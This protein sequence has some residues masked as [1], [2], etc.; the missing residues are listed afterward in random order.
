MICISC[1]AVI[2]PEYKF[3]IQQGVCPGCGQAMYSEE[4]KTLITEL[5]EVLQ[6]MPNDPEGLAGWFASNYEM[7]KIGSAEPTEFYSVKPKKLKKA[8]QEENDEEELDIEQKIANEKAKLFAKNAGVPNIKNLE[9]LAK[10][11]KS[12][13][14]AQTSLT[15][16]DVPEE[17]YGSSDQ[18]FE[19]EDP[20]MASLE[21]M[22]VNLKASPTANAKDMQALEIQKLKRLQS[23]QNFKS[24]GGSFTRS[25]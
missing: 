2:N 14:M 22:M 1:A 18:D 15:I 17:D 19:N 12:G 3:A 9:S 6:K 20:E 24:G 25:S 23:K 11:I 21:N 5:K 13:E 7:K 10:K 8:K 4:T 16:D